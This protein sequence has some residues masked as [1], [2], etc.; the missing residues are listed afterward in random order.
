MSL[1]KMDGVP[2]PVNIT[3]DEFSPYKMSE[4]FSSFLAG[5]LYHYQALV[6]F[7]APHHNSQWRHMSQQSFAGNY[8][9]WG[10]EN[11]ECAIRAISPLALNPNLTTNQQRPRGKGVEH[12]EI[13]TFDH[14]SNIFIA[15]ANLIVCGVDG[16]KRT[17]KLPQPVEGSPYYL[18]EKERQKR[19]INPISPSF[20]ERKKYLTPL[21]QPA[22]GQ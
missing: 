7:M 13:K 8:I 18:D 16:I 12:L 21:N 22:Q 10:F 15:L 1:W 4:G 2:T 14:T 6:T 9:A 5:V 20:N 11:K 3:G 17:M 19:G